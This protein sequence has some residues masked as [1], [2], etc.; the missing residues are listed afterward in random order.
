MCSMTQ[1]KKS[2]QRIGFPVGRKTPCGA[3]HS[4]V[5]PRSAL[6]PPHDPLP[7]VPG[8]CPPTPWTHSRP[9]RAH[10]RGRVPYARSTGPGQSAIPF[11][12]LSRSSLSLPNPHPQ[13]SPHHGRLHLARLP[14]RP[15]R[16]DRRG[17]RVVWRVS[18]PRLC[19]ST[20][21]LLRGGRADGPAEVIIGGGGGVGRAAESS[22]AG[23]QVRIRLRLRI[24][25]HP[26]GVV[27]GHHPPHLG[28]QGGALVDAG[29]PPRRLPSLSHHGRAHLERQR[30]RARR[31]AIHLLLLRA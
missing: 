21:W 31:P 14:L 12:A 24:L 3:S 23:V 18:T 10:L 5:R 26:E 8:P 7:Q 11:L 19:A 17:V 28:A 13:F 9:E 1:L 20:R 27:G 30:L 2:M 25:L 4:G 16:Q 15:L 22:E 6:R 29:L